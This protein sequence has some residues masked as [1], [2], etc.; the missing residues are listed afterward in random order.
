VFSLLIVPPLAL[1][2]TEFVEDFNDDSIDPVI[3]QDVHP[4]TEVTFADGKLVISEPG[5]LF[6]LPVAIPSFEMG[7]S[8]VSAQITVAFPH[9]RTGAELRIVFSASGNEIVISGGNS[10]GQGLVGADGQLAQVAA[11]PINALE[12]TL[13]YRRVRSCC[14]FTHY[15]EYDDGG[16]FQTLA[17]GTWGL[18]RDAIQEIRFSAGLANLDVFVMF[19]DFIVSSASGGLPAQLTD[20]DGDGVPDISDNCPG[21]PN[22][23]QE[24]TDDDGIGDACDLCPSDFTNDS[25]GDGLCDSA[26]P[27]PL[28]PNNDMDGDGLCANVDPCPDDPND[29]DGDGA[30]DSA[31]LCPL[32]ASNDADG[33]G[34]CGNVDNC[35]TVANANQTDTDGDG[36][37]DACE[38]DSD[39]DGVI[40][41]LDNCP[42]FANADQTDTDGD[43]IGDACDA[44]DDN[45]GVLDGTDSCPGTLPGEPVLAN[46][47]AVAQQCVCSASWKNHGA[48]VRCVAHAAEALLNAGHI[49]Q[50]EKDAVVSAAGQSSCGTKK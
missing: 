49:T 8:D 12:V 40:N 44:D 2:A 6:S 37:G 25:D 10:F 41:D 7:G 36:I 27:C 50:A 18:G 23:D 34:I 14:D 45:D 9:N 16:G 47:C 28:D 21:V 19:D 31:D 22:P 32:D 13:R 39:G 29:S 4:E 20:T 35:P 24:D 26:D 11:I 46:G 42:L 15:L 43:G 17:S 33:D 3:Q 38:P 30:C 5:A 1:A 48:Y